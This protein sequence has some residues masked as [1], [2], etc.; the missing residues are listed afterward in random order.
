MADDLESKL[1]RTI[2]DAM[3]EELERGRPGRDPGDLF[4]VAFSG[5]GIRSATFCLGVLQGLEKL[6]LL[7]FVDYLS[8]VSGGGYIGSWYLSCLKEQLKDGTQRKPAIKHLRGFSRYLAP[9]AGF[10][11]AD[12]WTIAMVWL[13]NTLLLQTMLASLFAVVLLS[14]RFFEYY[15]SG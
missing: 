10:F 4:G 14:P 13:R 1:D 9:Q 3:R 12:T 5:G 7:G 8:T 6:G 2:R 11:S 15:Y